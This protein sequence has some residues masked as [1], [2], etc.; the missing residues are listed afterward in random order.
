[1]RADGPMLESKVHRE[2]IETYEKRC[3]CVE[4]FVTQA[5]PQLE[6]RLFKLTDPLE[7]TPAETDV[8]VSALV[9]SEETLKGATKINDGR[10]QRGLQPL[11]LVIIPTI[12]ALGS[13]GDKLSSTALRAK[14]AGA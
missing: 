13:D 12:G 8:D 2:L 6:C 7:P 9:A 1:M 14:D 10:K 3:E 4:L 5:N 11:V